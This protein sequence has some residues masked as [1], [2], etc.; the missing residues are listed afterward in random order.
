MT[1]PRISAIHSSLTCSHYA[2]HTPAFQPSPSHSSLSIIAALPA[3]PLPATASPVFL[4]NAA[5]AAGA[6]AAS[7]AASLALACASLPC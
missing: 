3:A 1:G 5:P 4:T 7:M 6:G 2:R